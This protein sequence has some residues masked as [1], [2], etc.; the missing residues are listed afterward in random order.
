MFIEASSG[1]VMKFDFLKMKY[2]PLDFKYFL[3]LKDL[4]RSRLK[5]AKW[6]RNVWRLLFVAALI[7]LVIYVPI[8]EHQEGTVA[9]MDPM[10][11]PLWTKRTS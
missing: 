10:V 4:W 11:K 5:T 6:E 8:A 7:S 1:G 9:K 2:I 3:F